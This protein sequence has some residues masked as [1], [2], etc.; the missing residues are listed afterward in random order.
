MSIYLSRKSA[1]KIVDT[2]KDVCGHDINFINTD[3][4]IFASTNEI[5][6]GE[7]HE[8]GKKVIDTRE[9]IEVESDDN[10]YGT[11]KGVNIPIVYNHEIIAVI[12][13]SGFPDDVR[14][15]AVLAQKITAL[16]LREQEIELLNFGYKT[17]MNSV[18]HALIENKYIH[19]EF[20]KEF[21]EKRK[22]SIKENYRTLIIKPDSRYNPS[23]FAML[24]NEIYQFFNNIS[25]F[26]CSINYPND[27]WIMISDH[28]YL[29][30][31]K[32]IK[33]W[34]QDFRTILKI[35]IG[36]SE[37]IHRQNISYSKG[38]I[39]LKSLFGSRN[40][41]CYDELTLEI[42]TGS[43]TDNVSKAYKEKTIHQL[44]Q[45]D[46]KLL[47]IYFEHNLSLK[48][49]SEALFLHKNTIQYKLNKIQKLTGYDPRKFTEAVILYLA[50]RI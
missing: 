43:L 24:E 15:Y 27:Y 41:A 10:F 4:I 9:I 30:W 47:K 38:E 14:Q 34:A 36:S 22:L 44:N 16:L 46:L 42:I 5:R 7:F 12:G 29:I 28:D 26:M 18:I 40:I 19:Q 20:L 2:V 37:S 32:R 11:Q 13:I 49:T 39:A 48:E 8:I 21:L 31:K 1:Q 35:G 6:I 17:Q 25:S 3:G 23:N 33:H 50:I 45:E